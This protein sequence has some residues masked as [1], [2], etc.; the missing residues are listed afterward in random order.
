MFLVEWIGWHTE[1]NSWIDENNLYDGAEPLLATFLKGRE[2][3]FQR[4]LV[5]YVLSRVKS[6]LK[7]KKD[8]KN[9][10]ASD[11]S[12]ACRSS[13]ASSIA[14]TTSSSTHQC[15]LDPDL[16]DAATSNTIENSWMTTTSQR[17]NQPYSAYLTL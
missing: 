4:K 3:R 15:E 13:Q 16:S 6:Q 1:C 7:A 10:E 11:I 14:S 9:I 5:R 2:L 12:T 8:G 17:S